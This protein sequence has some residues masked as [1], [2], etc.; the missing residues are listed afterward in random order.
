M[1]IKTLVLFAD[2]RTGVDVRYY[3]FNYNNT[4]FEWVNNFEYTWVLQPKLQQGFFKQETSLF[5]LFSLSYAFWPHTFLCLNGRQ[6]RN[7]ILSLFPS[8]IFAVGISL[9]WRQLVVSIIGFRLFGKL[10]QKRRH[11]YSWFDI[12]SFIIHLKRYIDKYGDI[13]VKYEQRNFASNYDDRRVWVHEWWVTREDDTLILVFTKLW[14]KGCW[15]G[16]NPYQLNQEESC[17]RLWNIK[18]FAWQ[19][20]IKI[21]ELSS[22]RF[23]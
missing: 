4:E 15:V 23:T 2:G 10:T 5:H 20:L 6:E 14:Y 12:L 19:I 13:W 7:D 9:I 18:K 22:H 16:G 11:P 1:G 17:T 21:D 3:F 8:P